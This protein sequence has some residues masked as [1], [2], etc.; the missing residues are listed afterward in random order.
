MIKNYESLNQ[1]VLGTSQIG[2]RYGVTNKNLINEQIASKI[3]NFCKENNIKEIDT[4]INYYN[5][6]KILGKIGISE[7]TI[8]TKLPKQKDDIEDIE[9]WIN[10]QITDSLNRLNLTSINTLYLHNPKDLNSQLG[11][12]LYKKIEQLKADKLIK[13]I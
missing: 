2:S 11:E 1:L 8:S 7:F 5:S 4:A 10:N 6:E 12:R 3:I 9:G 13:N